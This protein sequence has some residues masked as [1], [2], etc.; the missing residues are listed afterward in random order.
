MEPTLEAVCDGVVVREPAKVA[1]EQERE[2][3][4][5]DESEQLAEACER[6]AR[7]SEGGEGEAP[8]WDVWTPGG[9][10]GRTACDAVARRAHGQSENTKRWRTAGHADDRGDRGERLGES[11]PPRC[12]G[13]RGSEVA[14][15]RRRGAAGADGGEEAEGDPD[16]AE[17]N[18]LRG[19][20]GEASGAGEDRQEK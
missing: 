1:P 3:A 18:G 7:A 17:D 6:G 16:R 15:E 12:V 4:E 11:P 20:E 19:G 14:E 13:V 2:D 8:Q 5:V 10:R 9:I